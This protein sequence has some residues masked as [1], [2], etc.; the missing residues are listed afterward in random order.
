MG[1]GCGSKTAKGF[2]FVFNILFFLLGAT[3]L[4]LGIF[5]LVDKAQLT[6]LTKLGGV[7]QV[8]VPGLLE[9]SAYVL[10]AGGGLVFIIGFLGCCGAWKEVR[11][12]LIVYAIMV[13]LILL[14]EIGAG[15]VA[16]LFRDKAITELKSFLNETIVYK[17]EGQLTTSEPFSLAWDLAHVTFD[18]CGINNST[19]F[20]VASA[21]NRSYTLTTNNISS[22]VNM[23]IPPSCCRFTDKSLYPSNIGSLTFVNDTCPIAPTT[24]NSWLNT[25]CYQTIYDFVLQNAYIIIGIGIGIGVVEIVGIVAAC[26]LARAI[27]QKENDVV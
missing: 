17:Y 19:D 15:V 18:C 10:I 2:L 23:V 4:G 16:F 12:F 11:V 14:A 9:T 13:L 5:V 27:K 25:G 3:A 6:Y 24:S 21:W 22:T 26:C 1:L 7:N 8:D 20:D